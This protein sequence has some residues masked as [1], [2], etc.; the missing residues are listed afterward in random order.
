MLL[1]MA[2]TP[3]TRSLALLTLVAFLSGCYK[4]VAPPGSIQEATA[5]GHRTVRVTTTSG[6]AVTLRNARVVEESLIGQDG[7]R[8]DTIPLTDVSWFQVQR[9]DTTRD[10]III[11]S[12][13]AGLA[14][15]AITF[16][17]AY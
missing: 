9:H 5:S 16:A 7:A 11:G 12:V 13:L 10:V 15:V 8:S 2:G 4:W 17:N 6:E 3:R 14:L 1:R